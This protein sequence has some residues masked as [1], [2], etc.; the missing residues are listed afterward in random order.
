MTARTKRQLD[1]GSF[2]TPGLTE[3]QRC[4]LEGT[5]RQIFKSRRAEAAAYLNAVERE[6][7]L[8][9]SSIERS[10]D[11]LLKT[12]LE[13]LQ[14]HAVPF[15]DALEQLGD[16]DLTAIRTRYW[17]ALKDQGI[18]SNLAWV[19]SGEAING[20][21]RAGEIARQFAEVVSGVGE[22]APEPSAEF[23]AERLAKAYCEIFGEPPSYVR[24]GWFARSLNSVMATAKIK[25]SLNSGPTKIASFGERPLKAIL[26]RAG[27]LGEP[28]RRGRKPRTK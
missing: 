15:A 16:N 1:T 13:R 2:V 28:L 3:A 4:D 6:I 10:T 8:Y 19:Q 27:L 11:Y 12:R 24:E 26:E 20:F 7:E 21:V 23:L 14:K 9:R 17:L 22:I 18:P 5:F 25:P